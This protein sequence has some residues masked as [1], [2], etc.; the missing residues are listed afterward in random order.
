MKAFDLNL[1]GVNVSSVR[2]A[3]ERYMEGITLSN[4]ANMNQA[5]HD[6]A[7]ICHAYGTNNSRAL[8]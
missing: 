7:G 3:V 6:I 8:Q 2:P 4:T 1:S 5:V